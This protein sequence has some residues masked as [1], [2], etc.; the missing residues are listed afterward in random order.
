MEE[1]DKA[2]AMEEN[3]ES[4]PTIKPDI[5]TSQGEK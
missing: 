3:I 4:I 2:K 5:A 1:V